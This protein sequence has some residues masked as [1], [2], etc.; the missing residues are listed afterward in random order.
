VTIAAALTP[1]F[2]ATADVAPPEPTTHGAWAQAPPGDTRAAVATT[3]VAAA[4]SEA[5]P[6]FTTPNK[7]RPLFWGLVAG[8][9]LLCAALGAN[10]RPKGDPKPTPDP[11][12]GT[13]P[14]ASS[15][16]PGYK[17]P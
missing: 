9:F 14:G 5:S 13:K 2:W 7:M 4:Q 11:K 8:A 15:A 3:D 10:D 12:P 16:P 17:T 1:A 6:A